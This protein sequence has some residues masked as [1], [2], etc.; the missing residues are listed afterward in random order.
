MH[1]SGSGLAVAAG[2]FPSNPSAITVQ[3]DK[4]NCIIFFMPE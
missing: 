1:C 4:L 3:S 2:V